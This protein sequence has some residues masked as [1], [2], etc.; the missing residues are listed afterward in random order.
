MEREDNIPSA[1]TR[2]VNLSL[3]VWNG[4]AGGGLVGSTFCGRWCVMSTY[5]YLLQLRERKSPQSGDFG[6]VHQ[7][8]L[9]T[10]FNDSCISHLISHGTPSLYPL[11]TPRLPTAPLPIGLQAA[12]KVDDGALE[13]I[14]R[15]LY[16][17]SNWPPRNSAASRAGRSATANHPGCTREHGRYPPLGPGR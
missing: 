12:H 2:A 3:S 17:G 14:T 11:F 9:R 1:S 15:D 5:L 4:L 8:S 7:V 13:I 6:I 16:C 10:I